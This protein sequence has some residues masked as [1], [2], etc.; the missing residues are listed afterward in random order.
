MICFCCSKKFHDASL[1]CVWYGDMV[2]YCNIQWGTW[3]KCWWKL[4]KSDLKPS[5]I[6]VAPRNSMMLH[7]SVFDME[8]W[9]FAVTYSGELE[10]SVGGSSPN[11]I[12]NPQL[13]MLMAS[14][15]QTNFFDLCLSNYFYRC[16]LTGKFSKHCCPRFL[17]EEVFNRLKVNLFLIS[18]QSVPCHPVVEKMP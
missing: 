12:S 18:W 5:I 14:K 17:E 15:I 2:I 10:L 6:L 11:Q 4:T 7:W 1:K 13:Y 3:I 9:S 16:C 8:T